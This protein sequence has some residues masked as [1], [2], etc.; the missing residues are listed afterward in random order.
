MAGDGRR[1]GQRKHPGNKLGR[2]TGPSLKQQRPHE[3][4][5][6]KKNEGVGEHARF[7]I[8]PGCLPKQAADETAG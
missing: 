1:N 7:E 3:R 4:R 2:A 8:P 5:P 6:F